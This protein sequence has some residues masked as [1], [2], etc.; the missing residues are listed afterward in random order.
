M[1]TLS[2]ILTEEQEKFLEYS[3][4]GYAGGANGL[5]CSICD[6][7]YSGGEAYPQICAVCKNRASNRAVLAGVV[8]MI[9]KKKKGAQCDTN[10]ILCCNDD[11][12][13]DISA[14]IS[15]AMNVQ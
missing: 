6:R 8:E 3:E 9:E 4:K 5:R 12:I 13:D 10:L 14:I 1:P 15:E 7:K 2:H 11:F